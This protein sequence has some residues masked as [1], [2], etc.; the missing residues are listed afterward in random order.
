MRMGDVLH[1]LPSQ[2]AASFGVL[3][4]KLTQNG[5]PSMCE[6]FEGAGL[7]ADSFHLLAD[8]LKLHCILAGGN[9]T[10]A[11]MRLRRFA[12]CLKE[13]LDPQ[14]QKYKGTLPQSPD[15]AYSPSFSSPRLSPGA[16]SREPWVRCRRKGRNSSSAVKMTISGVGLGQKVP[17][18]QSPS[19]TGTTRLSHT[20]EEGASDYLS[21][22]QAKPR[23]AYTAFCAF[24]F[25]KNIARF[26]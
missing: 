23:R 14:M 24:K 16:S 10:G 8:L 12:Y 9:T 13:V 21:H 25:F 2:N 22:P 26:L 20:A 15:G 5:L 4:M 7:V 1:H 6:R 3:R 19:P 11:A 17:N 18:H